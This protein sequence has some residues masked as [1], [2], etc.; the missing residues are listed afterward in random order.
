MKLKLIPPPL[1]VP[2]ERVEFPSSDVG[3]TLEISEETL[4]QI[5]EIE[6]N[7]RRAAM[8]APFIFFD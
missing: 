1:G 6:F 7:Q 3:F 5:K 8:L 4:R 2:I